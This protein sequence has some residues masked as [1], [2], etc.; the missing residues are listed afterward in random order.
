MLI[1][2]GIDTVKLNGLHFT[3]H[4][5]E[6]DRVKQGDLLIEFDQEAIRAAGFD[7]TTPI[8]ISNSDDYV[9]VLTSGQSPVQEQAPLLTLLR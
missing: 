2:V 6:G 5:K 7:T 4:I 1:H 8:I 3:A 9:D